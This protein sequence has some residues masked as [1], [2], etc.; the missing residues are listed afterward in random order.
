MSSSVNP[1]SFVMPPSIRQN[2]SIIIAMLGS[3]MTGHV[4]HGS[5]ID[6]HVFAD[7]L[8]GVSGA[9]DAEVRQK[10]CRSTRFRV[11]IRDLLPPPLLACTL[12]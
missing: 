1:V 8:E 10:A 2:T 9:L 11:Q 12:R 6:L 7:N 4:R 5:D 3:T